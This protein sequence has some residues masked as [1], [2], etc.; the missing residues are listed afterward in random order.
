MARAR[1]QRHK[2]GD[3][4]ASAGPSTSKKAASNVR[5]GGNDTAVGDNKCTT[6]KRRGRPPKTSKPEDDIEE[7]A[8]AKK[9]RKDRDTLRYEKQIKNH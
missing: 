5:K 8:P 9:Q 4:Q 7:P 3:S 2:S 1:G 6:P